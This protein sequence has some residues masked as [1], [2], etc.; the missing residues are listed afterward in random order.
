[1]DET[2]K[3]AKIGF[4]P[5]RTNEKRQKLVFSRGGRTKNGKNIISATAENQKQANSAFRLRPTNEKRRKLAFGHGRRV[6]NSKK[7]ISATADERKTTKTDFRPR[8]KSCHPL[9]LMHG[10]VYC[11]NRS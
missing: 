6:K 5:W 8:P 9:I 2:K 11:R 1:M 3:T 4:Q 10:S 7:S